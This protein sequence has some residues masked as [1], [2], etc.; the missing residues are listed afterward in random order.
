MAAH[1]K[2]EE[3]AEFIFAKK[4]DADY[5]RTAARINAHISACSECK[6]I[7]DTLLAT[8]EAAERHA[9]SQ[10]VR[11]GQSFLLKIQSLTKIA[12]EGLTMYHPMQ[13][14]I[15]KS[16][17]SSSQHEVME[18]VLIDDAGNRIRID[19]DGS[20]SLYF[21][22]SSVP[23]GRTVVLIPEDQ[24]QPEMVG[25]VEAYDRTTTRVRFEGIVPGNFRVKREA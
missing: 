15:V 16:M 13:A 19:E 9:T 1:P 10:L 6:T 3:I 22:R 2:F 7:Y 25:V 8:K 21:D 4:I 17:G 20:L 5:F 18:S 24:R 11:S 23:T 12:V 14:A